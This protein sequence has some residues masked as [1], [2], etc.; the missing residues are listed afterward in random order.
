L[1]ITAGEYPVFIILN[2]PESMTKKDDFLKYKLTGNGQVLSEEKI[3]KFIEDFKNNKL[4]NLLSSDPVPNPKVIKG[5]EVVVGLSISDFANYPGRDSLLS[6]CTAISVRCRNLNK[7]L[8]YLSTRLSN[9]TIAIGQIDY[10]TNEFEHVNYEIIPTILLFRDSGDKKDRYSEKSIVYFNDTITTKNIIE[11]VKKNAFHAPILTRNNTKLTEA[12]QLKEENEQDKLE[13]TFNIERLSVEDENDFKTDDEIAEAANQKKKEMTDQEKEI[14]ARKE[15]EKK[16]IED[17]EP[18]LQEPEGFDS[19]HEAELPIDEQLK[20]AK[21][22]GMH[23]TKARS[24]KDKKKR[25]LVI[26]NV[27]RDRKI[28]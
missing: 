24:S 8:Q 13:R 1:R 22:G 20:A 5:L 3:S 10:N 11:F 18:D 9:K 25:W 15:Q 4:V 27:C 17:E 23:E 26:K 2:P 28:L 12:E 6:V 14:E 19:E 21:E 16:E 7:V